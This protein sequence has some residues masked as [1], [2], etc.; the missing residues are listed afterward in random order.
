MSGRDLVGIAR[1]G[2]GKTFA[3]LLPLLRLWSYSKQKL[4][5]IVVLVPTRELVAQVVE[6]A[7]VLTSYLSFDTV[8]VYGGVNMKNQ[9]NELMNGCDLVV[10]TPGRFIDLAAAGVLKVKDIKKL[11]IDEFDMM[12]D[13]GFKPQLDIIMDKIPERRQNLLFSATISSEIEELVQEIFVNPEIIE[14]S[15]VGTPLANI[16]QK[17]Y[18]VENFKT[19]INFLEVLLTNDSEMKKNL[20]FVSQK[21]S[22][23]Y[24]FNEL[25]NRGE[26]SLEV[27]H[28]NKSQNYRFRAIKAFSEGEIRTL[29]STDIGSRGL[30]I[31][32]IS[33]VV[34]MDIPVE[35]DDYIHR[36]GRTGRGANFGT[37]ISFISP[38]EA[39]DFKKIEDYYNITI[40][41]L[42]LPDYIEIEDGLMSFEVE[43]EYIKLP[44]VKPDTDKGAAFHEKLEKNTKVNVRRNFEAEMKKK[45]GKQYRKNR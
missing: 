13:L 41:T 21:S 33:H 11:V 8:G 32:N 17:A 2:T 29:I 35:S 5:Q 4:P 31:Q 45:Y 34:N 19:K 44:E 3:Y 18:W 40:P 28:S 43:K 20:I 6:N 25:K 14:D 37:A 42:D 39:D 10:A 15:D 36:I 23:D 22:A 12:L 9:A 38:R 26:Q 7:R 24:L 16:H 30:D 27:I 1:T